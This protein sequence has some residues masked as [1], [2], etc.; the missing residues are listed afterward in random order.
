[1]T[2][3]D[4]AYEMTVRSIRE[5]GSWSVQYVLGGADPAGI[6]SPFLRA[7]PTTDGYFLSAKRPLWIVLLV[8]ADEVGGVFGQR[9]LILCCGAAVVALT[10][11]IATAAGVPRA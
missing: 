9:L 2:S 8:G 11:C 3:D 1:M 7:K 6:G 10:G 5:D 4:G